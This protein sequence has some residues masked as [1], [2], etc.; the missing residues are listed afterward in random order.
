MTKE[1]K[2]RQIKFYLKCYSRIV[3][4]GSM[5]KKSMYRQVRLVNRAIREIGRC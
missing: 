5:S 2:Q 1:W 4:F 3:V